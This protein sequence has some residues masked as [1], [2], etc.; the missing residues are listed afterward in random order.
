MLVNQ[1][2]VMAAFTNF[3]TVF[4]KAF[5]NIETQ[6]Q[7]TAML[8]PS[9]TKIEIYVWLSN[10]P[11]MRDWFGDK[12]I[13]QLKVYKYS[14]ENIPKESTIE[15]DRDDIRDDRLGIYLPQAQMAAYAAATL[16]DDT[17]DDV[18]NA[19]FTTECYDGQYFYDTDHPVGNDTAENPIVSVSNLGTAALSAATTDLAVASYGAGRL[20]ILQFKSNEGRFLKLMPDTLEVPPALEATAKLLLFSD[21]LTDES[22]NPYKGTAR[23]LV[24]PG[25]TSS[26]AWFLHVTKFPIKP[27]IYQEREKATFVSQTSTD[28]DDVFN[29]KKFKFGAEARCAGGYGMWPLSY[30]STGAA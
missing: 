25:L 23:L 13:D 7:L 14:L 21:K 20:A 5:Y 1:A 16:P 30:A 11:K 19:A 4:N 27:F 15:V 17:I 26:T 12:T 18:K 28:S 24:N 3:K 29:R 9:K 8:S 22:P 10:F 2:S 6:W